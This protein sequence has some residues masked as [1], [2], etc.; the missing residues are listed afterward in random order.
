MF[1]S[2][3]T[4]NALKTV[5]TIDA[6]DLALLDNPNLRAIFFLKS[7]LALYFTRLQENKSMLFLVKENIYLLLNTSSFEHEGSFTLNDKDT[8]KC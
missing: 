3:S 8:L 1:L 7:E 5:K 6:L 2:A 4:C